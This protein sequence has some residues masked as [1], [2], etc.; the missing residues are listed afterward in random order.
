MR[1]NIRINK[2]NNFFLILK[3]STYSNITFFR[4]CHV[5]Y[6]ILGNIFYQKKDLSK[7]QRLFIVN[8]LCERNE[9]ILSK[10]VHKYS[11]KICPQFEPMS[12]L[13]CTSTVL[14]LAVLLFS[15]LFHVNKLC[16]SHFYFITF[17]ECYIL[18]IVLM[19]VDPYP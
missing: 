6:I 11:A 15:N 18:T 12:C 8:S 17:F 5:V 9:N 19:N 7:E 4:F 1:Q 3:N 2:I 14:L 10:S 13:E 16:C